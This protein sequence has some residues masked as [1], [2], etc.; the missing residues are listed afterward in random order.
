ME[1][2]RRKRGEGAGERGMTSYLLQLIGCS[3]PLGVTSPL[4]CFSHSHLPIS[5]CFP[6][7][8]CCQGDSKS[9]SLSKGKAVH[10]MPD[11]SSARVRGNNIQLTTITVNSLLSLCF[12]KSCQINMTGRGANELCVPGL[13]GEINRIPAHSHR[14]KLRSSP[15]LFK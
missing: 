5:P 3:A 8:C 11:T 1:W 9:C 6:V 15:A 2:P 10:Y 7:G 14:S 13:G 4:L 12:A